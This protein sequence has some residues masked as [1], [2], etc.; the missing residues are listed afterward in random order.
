MLT[1]IP[2]GSVFFAWCVLM[3]VAPIR[4]PRVLATQS[5]LFAS[6]VN[7]L[8][9]LF[10][11]IVVVSV[12]PDVID[13]ELGTFHGAVSVG[14]AAVTLVGLALIAVRATQT[15]AAVDAALDQALRTEYRAGSSGDRWLRREQRS[16]TGRRHRWASILFMP[17][18][19]RPRSVERVKDLAYGDRGTTNLLDVYRHRSRPAH[20]PTLVHFHG[21]YFRWGRKSLY[22]RALLFRFARNGW[23]CIS[24]N[25]HLSGTPADGFPQHLID[26][27][28]VVAWARTSGAQY[29]VD[30]DAILVAG[31]SAGAHLTAM[32][33]LT[34]NDPVFQPGFETVD[35]AIA[36]GICLYGY[37]GR[38]GGD[39]HPPTTPLDY[40]R[41]DA[42]PLF[43]AHGTLDPLTPID[44]VRAQV[45]RLRD[46]STSP[47]VYAELPGGHHSF[48]LYHSLRFETVVDGIEVFAASVRSID[49]DVHTA[50]P[51]RRD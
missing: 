20:A 5:F 6:V 25:Y 35:T 22:A 4:R 21:G 39:E 16:G 24:A 34:A 49:L 50:C 13:G 17:W 32:V 27:K 41:A 10:G 11:L 44:G 1:N 40:V 28:R 23:T 14:L 29:G 2:F 19:I 31:S 36:G 30:P 15:G 9:F 7:E 51:P 45:D 48:D 47:V 18:P 42:P 12:A 43:V 3:A 33:A 46:V 37:Y 8:P 38:L 26:A